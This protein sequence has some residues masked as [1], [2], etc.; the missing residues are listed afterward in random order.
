MTPVAVTDDGRHESKYSTRPATSRRQSLNHKSSSSDL[1]LV[2]LHEGIPSPVIHKEGK[3]SN[4][5]SH[6]SSP[7]HGKSD[8]VST[9]Q[10]PQKLSKLLNTSLSQEDNHHDITRTRFLDPASISLLANQSAELLER[11]SNQLHN[12]GRRLLDVDLLRTIADC[13]N[14]RAVTDVQSLRAVN[15]EHKLEMLRNHIK[16]LEEG[17]DFT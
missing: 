15:I 9:P 16:W 14:L 17:H 2:S 7:I 4:N 1:D 5:S 6:N 13:A 12:D 10:P 8:R 3:R 11:Q